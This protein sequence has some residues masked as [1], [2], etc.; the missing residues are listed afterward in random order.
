V[1]DAEARALAPG[2]EGTLELVDERHGP[3]GRDVGP[4]LER[5]VRRVAG[6]EGRARAMGDGT[7][8]SRLATGAGAPAA[9]GRGRAQPEGK[10]PWRLPSVSAHVS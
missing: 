9:P 8:P 6:R 7:I 4:D 3:Q 5:D 1:H 10:L 2:G